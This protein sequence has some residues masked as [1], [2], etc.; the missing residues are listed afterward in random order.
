[1]ILLSEHAQT[2]GGHGLRLVRE[3]TER[4]ALAR[5]IAREALLSGGVILLDTSLDAD[6]SRVAHFVE[7]MRPARREAIVAARR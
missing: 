4:F 1:M 3:L 5:L 6:A 2:F 7:S